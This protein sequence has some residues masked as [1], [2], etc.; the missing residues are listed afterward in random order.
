MCPR[1]G[2]RRNPPLRPSPRLPDI[3]SG[4]P[5]TTGTVAGRPN[6]ARAAS[7][8]GPSTSFVGSSSG[9]LPAVHPG[10]PHQHVRVADAR[11]VTR[12]R[13]PVQ[14]R[15]GPGG[16]RAA[17][18]LQTQPVDR[19]EEA[20]GRGVHLRALGAQPQDVPEGVTAGEGRRSP[21]QPQPAQQLHGA[22]AGH[23]Q[24]ASGEPTRVRR[25]PRVEPDDGVAER[26]AALVDGHG[27][28]PLAGQRHAANGRGALAVA[29]QQ[30][31]C[32]RRRCTPPVARALLGTTARARDHLRA[33]ELA[34][35]NL[36]AHESRARPLGHPCRGRWRAWRSREAITEGA[37]GLP[38]GGG[39][40]APEPDR[41]RETVNQVRVHA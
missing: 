32:R 34:V 15:R 28:G 17:G 5:A 22:V 6:S 33:L 40:S 24:R 20:P 36:A 35:H 7:V 29:R 38:H 16:S 30:P 39:R 18:E 31:A 12:V 2:E 26:L 14:G 4:V 1:T 27:P 37:C 21:R 11:Q 9:S 3:V 13:E 25:A 41:V 23:A 19:L 10:H 8:K